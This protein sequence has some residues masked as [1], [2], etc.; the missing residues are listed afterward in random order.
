MAKVAFKTVE[1]ELL[2]KIGEGILQAK[3]TNQE[4]MIAQRL[5]KY[6]NN[7]RLKPKL[8]ITYTAIGV[9]IMPY[10]KS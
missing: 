6:P 3:L 7:S 1:D 5:T 9:K 8:T 2:E 10:R 4:L